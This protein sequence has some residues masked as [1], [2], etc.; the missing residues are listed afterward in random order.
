MIRCICSL[1]AAVFLA[2]TA[3]ADNYVIVFTT[4]SGD[5]PTSGSFSYDT[6]TGFS[7]FLVVWDG[8]TF[9]LTHVFNDGTGGGVVSGDCGLTGSALGFAAI[10][11]TLPLSCEPTQGGWTANITGGFGFHNE[12][13]NF[14]P[15]LLYCTNCLGVGGPTCGFG[16][17]PAGGAVSGSGSG[18]FAI[19]DTNPATS[20]VIGPSGPIAMGPNVRPDFFQIGYAAHLGTSDSVVNITNDGASDP[21]GTAGNLCVNVYAF[22]A[23]EEMLSCCGC[24]VTPNGLVSLSLKN[25]LFTIT[26]AKPPSVV[27]DLLATDCNGQLASGMRA[28]GTTLHALPVSGF[29]RTEN[30]FADGTLSQGELDHLTSFCS[31]IQSDGSGQG[32]CGCSPGGF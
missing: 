20:P 11:K 3:F 32:T 18:D 5:A 15:N 1:I 13:F 30:S 28:W 26:G 22:D 8:Y 14:G 7:N 6:A 4:T 2:V 19:V 24:T 17:V 10:S 25:S 12:F 27:V 29:G 23:S 16:C 21:P 9:D 31:F